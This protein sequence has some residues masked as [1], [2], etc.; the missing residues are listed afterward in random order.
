MFSHLLGIIFSYRI[1]HGP[2]RTLQ[3]FKQLWSYFSS[4]SPGRWG[5]KKQPELE[6]FHEV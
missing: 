5:F 1:S 3:A 6:Y 2:T 4:R